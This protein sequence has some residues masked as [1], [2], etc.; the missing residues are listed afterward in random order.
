VD[1]IYYTYLLKHVPT[2][3]FYYG[4]SYKKNANP[5]FLW[6]TY[7]TSSKYVK[8]LIEEFGKDSFIFEIRKTF[9]SSDSCRKWETDVLCKID[10]ARN[11]KWLNRHNGSTNF[12]CVS[13]TDETKSKISKSG[14]GR[15]HSEETKLKM[16]K[17]K[18]I[19]FGGKVSLAQKGK[20]VSPEIGKKISA[21]KLGVPN[22]KLRETLKKNKRI[23]WNCGLRGNSGQVPWNKGKTF[24]FKP[25]GPYKQVVV[26]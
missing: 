2:N 8:E 25:R 1:T 11:D 18:P 6:K 4:S 10:A 7:Y 3:R 17:P 16:R 20:Y 19:G 13:H 9:T 14:I 5:Y 15:K 21:T 23:S 12:R 24:P 26:S 22:L